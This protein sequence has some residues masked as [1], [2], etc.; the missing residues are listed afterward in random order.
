MRALIT[1][2]LLRLR[3]IRTPALA[4][5][6]AVVVLVSNAIPMAG[7]P[8]NAA[9]VA[10]QLRG[11]VQMAVFFALAFAAVSVGDGFQRGEVAMTYTAHPHRDRVA[12]AH[13][14]TYAGVGAALASVASAVAVATTLSVAAAHHVNTGLSV[15]DLALTMAG[16]AVAGAVFGAVG[17]MVGSLTRRATI[18]V[19][20]A[21]VWQFGETFATRGRSSD[22]A[23]G[24]YLQIQ[25]VGAA[26]HLDK[27]VPTI[28]AAALLLAYLAA[29]G[30]TVRQW[31]R[32]RD[33]A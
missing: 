20:A 2:E 5:L 1:A 22:S 6:G 26:T 19:G 18:G 21:V 7:S 10:T 32:R 23:A 28:V 16:V 33:L 8:S 24:K 29:F 13:A 11:L 17:A 12:A 25:L 9:D 4:A 3:T 15:A 27:N 31:A 14:I 30:M